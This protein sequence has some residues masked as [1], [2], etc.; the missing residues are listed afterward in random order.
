MLSTRK[1]QIFLSMV[2]S[3]EMFE[4]FVHPNYTL[5]TWMEV[6]T[7]S[8]SI[9]KKL[10]NNTWE[11]AIEG[12]VIN[13]QEPCHGEIRATLLDENQV[14]AQHTTSAY[15]HDQ[16]T[17]RLCLNVANPHLWMGTDDPHL[18]QLSIELCTD[19]KVIEHRSISIGFRSIQI[20]PDQGLF[21]NGKH[22]KLR[23]VA[24]HQDFAGVGKCYFRNSNGA[25]Y[26]N[27]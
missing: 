20:T 9:R 18:H 17:F 12:C 13:H 23:G 25:G 24:R 22:V 8:E 3:T 6:V 1:W 4:L 15:F 10:E 27:S 14:I 5:T 7:V 21:L 2:D 26:P 16:N 19:K 11:V